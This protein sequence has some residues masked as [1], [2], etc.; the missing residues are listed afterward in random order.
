MPWRVASL[1]V[2]LLVSALGVLV[3]QGMA[4]PRDVRLA[5]PPPPS[6]AE[7]AQANCPADLAKAADT[8]SWSLPASEHHASPV[9][10][11]IERWSGDA[12][13][14]AATRQGRYLAENVR[15][16][17]GQLVILARRHCDTPT[18]AN[19]TAGRCSGHQGRPQY[20]V[21]RAHV[22]GFGMAGA[23]FEW[24]FVATVPQDSADGARSALWLLNDWRA[25]YCDET[26]AEIDVLEWYSSTHDARSTTHA[27]CTWNPDRTTS[28][29]TVD[30][31]SPADDPDVPP[32]DWT[33][34]HTWTVEKRTNQAR[35]TVEVTYLLDGEV[36][37]THSCTS[38]RL[39]FEDC[40]AA[41]SEGWQGIL[42]T[43]VFSG[44]SGVF[45]G[46]DASARF[47]TQRL[48]ISDMWFH[49]L[50]R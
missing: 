23:D 1:V 20:S 31:G 29:V 30:A 10:H 3:A 50:P 8:I 15:L 11:T 26:Y 42:Q 45:T 43:A 19:E 27:T 46:P 40:D 48:V 16:E 7:V 44:R 41:F 2:T 22:Q 33:R 13:C 37:S 24:G 39:A 28:K 32:V 17:N 49:P 12:S 4:E 47:P 34:P 35:R 9:T 25:A 21:G 36:Y 14:E 5:P 18:D 6:P 38:A